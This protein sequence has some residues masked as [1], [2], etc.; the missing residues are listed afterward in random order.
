LGLLDKVYDPTICRE[1]GRQKA[2]ER[3]LVELERCPSAT[4]DGCRALIYTAE[5][6]KALAELE[7][8]DA[9]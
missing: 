4:V 9:K 7:K 5:L 8:H 3:I 6:H 1:V 2:M